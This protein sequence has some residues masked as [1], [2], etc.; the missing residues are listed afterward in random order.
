MKKLPEKINSIIGKHSVHYFEVYTINVDEDTQTDICID[1]LKYDRLEKSDI[2]VDD[3]NEF[4]NGFKV[5][6]TKNGEYA[7]VREV[8]NVLLPYRYD[9][10]SNFNEYG[11][12][13]VGKGG[14]VSWIDKE[15]KYL[16]LDGNMHFNNLQDSY[17]G[18]DGWKGVSDFS[19]GSTPLSRVYYGQNG[20]NTIAYFG[21]DGEVKSFYR[22]NVDIEE[23]DCF[24]STKLL[25]Q[26][27]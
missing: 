7:Y 18:F 16:A 10:A 1:L 22:Y 24:S 25:S 6:Q 9:I 8:D 23:I 11:F 20:C 13:M 5:V 17:F 27:A 15:F 4:V 21:I 3:S 19:K 26:V 14:R 2:I 12:A